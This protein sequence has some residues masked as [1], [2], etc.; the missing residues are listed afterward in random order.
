MALCDQL[1]AQLTAT[2]NTRRQLLEATLHAALQ[3]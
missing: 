2:T 3:T 1:E